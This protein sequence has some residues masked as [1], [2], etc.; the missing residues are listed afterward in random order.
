MRK[1]TLSLDKELLTTMGGPSLDGAV[2]PNIALLS[3]ELLWL[4]RP[5]DEPPLSGSFDPDRPKPPTKWY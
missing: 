4:V 5:S 1:S 2:A 3:V